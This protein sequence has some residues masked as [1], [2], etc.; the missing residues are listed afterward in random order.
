[1]NTI[2]VMVP[3]IIRQRG[4]RKAVVAPD[5]AA[6]APPLGVS[7]PHADQSAG[8]SVP[9]AADARI[10][11]YRHGRRDHWKGED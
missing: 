6:W 7:G 9:V 1:M 10:R 8:A 11:H 2:T 4:G 3:L 5:G